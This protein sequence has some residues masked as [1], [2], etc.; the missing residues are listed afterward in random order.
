MGR[1]LLKKQKEELDKLMKEITDEANNVRKDYEK[2]P[3]KESGSYIHF[4]ENSP[5]L[6]EKNERLITF[7]N[8]KLGK[9]KNN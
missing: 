1:Q 2:N 9:K 8:K 7:D 6:A 5:Y 4:H 3:S